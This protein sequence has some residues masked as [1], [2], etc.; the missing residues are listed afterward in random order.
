M[1]HASL[2]KAGEINTQAGAVIISPSDIQVVTDLLNGG[3]TD[4]LVILEQILTK[5]C[6]C[7]TKNL[8]PD[9]ITG[10][11]PIHT[12]LQAQRK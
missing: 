5:C 1:S 3:Q 2:T 9:Q 6:N 12:Q 4:E 11:A 7:M 8:T 10:L